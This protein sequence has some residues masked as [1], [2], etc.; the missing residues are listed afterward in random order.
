[1]ESWRIGVKFLLLFESIHAKYSLFLLII[2]KVHLHEQNNN[3]A[4]YFPQQRAGNHLVELEG[5][6]RKCEGVIFN[7]FENNYMSLTYKLYD[8]K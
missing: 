7:F 3:I 8:W 1:M 5:D 4:Q 2:L 6:P